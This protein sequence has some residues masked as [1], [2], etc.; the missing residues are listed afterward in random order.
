MRG[1][2]QLKPVILS[3]D[4]DDYTREMLETLLLREFGR[5]YT[6]E[7]AASGNDGLAILAQWETKGVTPAVILSGTQ[8]MDMSG[9]YFLD[10]TQRLWPM[11]KTML[12]SNGDEH[13]GIIR[14]MWGIQSG[15]YPFDVWGKSDFMKGVRENLEAFEKQE[16]IEI[17]PPRLE[18][19]KARFQKINQVLENAVERQ[20]EELRRQNSLLQQLF[21]NSQDGMLIYDTSDGIIDVNAAFANLLQYSRGDVMGRR[22]DDTIIPPLLRHMPDNLQAAI[23]TGVAFSRDV[24]CYRKDRRMVVLQVSGYPYKEGGKKG[25]MFI[26][27]RDV[28]DQHRRENLQRMAYDRQRQTDF[29]NSMLA[30]RSGST[31]ETIQ[32]AQQINLDLSRPF[33]LYFV[34]VQQE[35]EKR[36]MGTARQTTVSSSMVDSVIEV[37]STEPDIVAWN[38]CQ[39]VGVLCF[40]KMASLERHQEEIARASDLRSRLAATIP[41]CNTVWGIAEFQTDINL[42]ARRYRQARHAAI[43]GSCFRINEGVFH[44]T[45][46]SA[47][48]LLA[49]M[50]GQE[51][52]DS[53]IERTIGKVLLYDQ[54]H[55][56]QLFI[57]LEKI[58]AQNNLRAAAEELFVHYK[59]ILFRKQSLERILGISLESFDSRMMLGLALTLHRFQNIAMESVPTGIS[60]SPQGLM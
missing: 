17:Q 22:L 44:F 37:L 26:V 18:V 54:E 53:F 33:T 32:K 19:M 20:T 4:H 16:Q 38:T 41:A 24:Q 28:S 5:D 59:T 31:A 50:V 58:I 34:L 60:P 45:D 1:G 56:T 7:T 51:N 49:Q 2:D 40:R 27:C 42:F 29:L 11:A 52:V 30:G 46:D 47:F 48:P 57:T 12:L 3:V 23:D 15:H 39:G 25:G 55:G 43:A 6:V 21:H 36:K 13:G 14:P 9:E 35:K 8:L 10:A